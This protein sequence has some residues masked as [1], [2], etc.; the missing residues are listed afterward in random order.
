[1]RPSAPAVTKPKPRAAADARL[2]A[3]FA[4]EGGWDVHGRAPGFYDRR[5]HRATECLRESAAEGSPA[6]TAK[7]T[8]DR[9]PRPPG[10][11]GGDG[12]E[13]KRSSSWAPHIGAIAA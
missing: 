5:R 1:M 8:S 9:T 10:R 2:G 4:G 13:C 3:L 6:A 7:I 11:G 12:Y